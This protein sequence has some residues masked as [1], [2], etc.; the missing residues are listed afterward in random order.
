MSL[1]VHVVLHVRCAIKRALGVFHLQVY[2][3]GCGRVEC[4]YGDGE[5]ERDGGRG[6]EEAGVSLHGDLRRSETRHGSARNQHPEERLRQSE[7]HDPR[8]GAPQHVQPQVW[9]WRTSLLMQWCPV[10]TTRWRHLDEA[11]R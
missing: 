6:A 7:P 1:F 3:G 2:D 11:C 5:G 8:L 9:M 10:Y 4:V